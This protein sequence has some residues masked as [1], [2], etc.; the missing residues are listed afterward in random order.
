VKYIPEEI[1]EG[2]LY[3]SVDYSTASHNCFC[4]CGNRVVT[5][6]SPTDWKLIFN[7]KS[8]SL[9]PSIGNWGFQ[10]QSHY[11]IIEDK[12]HLAEQ[13]SDEEIWENREFDRINK[14]KFFE[15][16]KHSNQENL[17]RKIFNQI[18]RG[19]ITL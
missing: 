1:D 13:W 14:K 17:F 6:L 18:K 16:S 15:Q 11:W 12:I 10:C 3:V 9:S 2:V 5:P 8:V 19:L 7:G 4:G